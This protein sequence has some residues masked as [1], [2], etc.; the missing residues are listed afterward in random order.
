[1]EKATFL[2]I[3]NAFTKRSITQEE[4]AEEIRGSK[5]DSFS[6]YALLGQL[7]KQSGIFPDDA[8]LMK[9]VTFNDLF[10]FYSSEKEIV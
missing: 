5:I 1:M 6:F 10:A 7:S 2:K 9:I 3:L 4:M 8:T